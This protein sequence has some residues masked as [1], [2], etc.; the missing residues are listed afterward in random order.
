MARFPKILGLL[1]LYLG[2]SFLL[3]ESFSAPD[4]LS[5]L[6]L[7]FYFII[8]LLYFK[9]PAHF[10]IVYILFQV[11]KDHPLNYITQD[12][13]HQG[14]AIRNIDAI[15]IVYL[16]LLVIIF[17]LARGA[18]FQI[19]PK[20]LFFPMGFVLLLGL[21]SG[22]YQHVP[23]FILFHG[24][25]FT[26]KGFI[27]YLIFLNMYI[28]NYN[29]YCRK[30]SY[31]LILLSLI[32]LMA[33]VPNLAFP[34]EMINFFGFPEVIFKEPRWFLPSVQSIFAHPKSFCWFIAFA[35]F[36]CFSL[37]LI[38]KY[39]WAVFSMIGFFVG[40]FLSMR[41]TELVA[42]VV[43]LCSV[44][45]MRVEGISLKK[46][47]FYPIII[48]MLLIPAAGVLRVQFEDAFKRYVIGKNVENVPR[49]V[50]SLTS[51]DLANK[52]F[53][54]GV[55]FGRFG[56]PTAARYYSPVYY[57]TGLNKIKGLREEDK[58][59]GETFLTDTFYPHIIAETGWFGFISFIVFII[60]I[61]IIVKQINHHMPQKLGFLKAY[62][63]TIYCY[64]IFVSIVSI[65]VYAFE[66]PVSQILAYGG[67]GI[68]VNYYQSRTINP[69]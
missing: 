5:L 69:K 62:A 10:T 41:R 1:A 19:G 39:L 68:L 6:I 18:R 63:I 65:A 23:L 26:I 38:K 13:Y 61:I 60:F 52:R 2:I 17:N 15:F 59:L 33:I 58:A 32:F 56:S 51:I 55:G 21:V 42:T 12:V 45:L 47:L 24:A 8:S 57:E 66:D 20:K 37:F 14:Q 34:K 53:P 16:L 48:L 7:A 28:A 30:V 22:F 46:K 3:V 31:G 35:L 49:I 67:L 27:I 44:M 40:I 25:Y 43:S 54:L 64:F 29:D 4:K 11:V 9:E 50:L 36:L